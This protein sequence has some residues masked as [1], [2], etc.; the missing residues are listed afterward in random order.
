VRPEGEFGPCR[1]FLTQP[2][3]GTEEG[4]HSLHRLEPPDEENAPR[5]LRGFTARATNRAD[6]NAIGDEQSIRPPELLRTLNEC[7][8]D[9]DHTIDVPMHEPHEK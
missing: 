4:I 7:A 1:R 5:Y 6:I 3:E 2:R 9:H 8:T